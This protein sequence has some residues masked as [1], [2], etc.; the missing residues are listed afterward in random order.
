MK[1]FVGPEAKYGGRR[2]N[3]CGTNPDRD[4]SLNLHHLNKMPRKEAPKLGLVSNTSFHGGRAG[5]RISSHSCACQQQAITLVN[6]T[7]V[8]RTP[9]ISCVW[10]VSTLPAKISAYSRLNMATSDKTYAKP[11]NLPHYF[12]KF[13]QIY[14][15][16]SGNSTLN[17]F[18]SITSHLAPISAQSVLHDNA[19]G[20]GTATSVILRDLSED[21]YPKVI[22]TDMVPAMIDAFNSTIV[23]PNAALDKFTGIVMK[24]EKLDFPDAYFTHSVTNFSIFNFV[25]QQASVSEIYRTLRP[26]GQAVISTWKFFG[27]GD[28]VHEIQRQIRPDLPLLEF[29]GAQWHSADAVVDLMTKAGF[30]KQNIEVLSRKVVASGEDL[31]GLVEF[32]TGPFTEPARAEWTDNEKGRWKEVLQDVFNEKKR[33]YGGVVF[34]GWVI[35]ATK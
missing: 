32:A 15:R 23:E 17:L 31:D 16:Q 27:I 6:S 3:E 28:V 8:T 19:S 4:E 35:L 13:S 18:S 21:A 26:S 9:Y 10:N 34:E 25:D 20:P 29:S 14:A 2:N 12:N 7:K 11:S 24:S 5:Y 30:E 1:T 33:D 22:A